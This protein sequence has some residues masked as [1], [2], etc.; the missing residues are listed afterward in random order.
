[1]A[2]NT[3][4]NSSGNVVRLLGVNHAGSEYACIQGWG[5][6]EGTIDQTFVNSLLSWHV[7]ALRLPLNE[8]C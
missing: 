6:T 8:D 2:G 3:I 4:R 1:M 7:D 5:M